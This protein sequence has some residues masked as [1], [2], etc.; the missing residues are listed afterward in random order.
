MI[1]SLIGNIAS[2][3]VAIDLEQRGQTLVSACSSATHSIGEAF[4]SIRN[5]QAD[6]MIAG[7]SEAAVANLVMLV[8]LYESNEHKF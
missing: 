6:V 8:L 4:N 5:N 2:G 1:P 3:V 7:G